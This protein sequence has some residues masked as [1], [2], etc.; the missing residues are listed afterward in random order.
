MRHD[1][2]RGSLGSAIVCR[3]SKQELFLFFRF[4]RGL[5]ED[6]PV[7]AIVEDARIE[8]IV[9]PLSSRPFGICFHEV[10]VWEL[11]LGVLVEVLHVRVL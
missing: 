7:P 11:P 1:V 3:Y 4:L 9:L 10:S 6:V 2:K 5:D 8:K